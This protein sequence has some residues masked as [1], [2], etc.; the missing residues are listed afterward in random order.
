MLYSTTYGWSGKSGNNIY[1][2]LDVTKADFIRIMDG[3]RVFR[4][5]Y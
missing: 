5:T 1:F 3:K 4:Y 2:R